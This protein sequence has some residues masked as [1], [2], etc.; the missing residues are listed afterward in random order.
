MKNMNITRKWS[1]NTIKS[2]TRREG[3]RVWSRLLARRRGR[4]HIGIEW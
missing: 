3:A 1:N 4:E 2:T